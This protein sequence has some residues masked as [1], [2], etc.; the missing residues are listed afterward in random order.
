MLKSLSEKKSLNLFKEEFNE[1]PHGF[2]LK[3]QEVIQKKVYVV[4]HGEVKEEY[5]LF[6]DILFNS[7]AWE[8][9]GDTFTFLTSHINLM[10]S[11]MLK[12]NHSSTSNDKLGKKSILLNFITLLKDKN[13]RKSL[14]KPL[15]NYLNV[16]DKNELLN[17]AKKEKFEIR[18]FAISNDILSVY[19]L[20]PSNS[21]EEEV[22]NLISIFNQNKFNTSVGINLDNI[23]SLTESGK[24]LFMEK[25]MLEIDNEL[26]TKKVRATS[27][28]S[29]QPFSRVLAKIKDVLDDKTKSDLLRRIPQLTYYREISS[30]LSMKFGS[31]NFIGTPWDRLIEI[32]LLNKEI[33]SRLSDKEQHTYSKEDLKRIFKV[34]QTENAWNDVVLKDKDKFKHV[35]SHMGKNVVFA[36]MPL[37]YEA[38]INVF[39]EVLK[40]MDK[41]EIGRG[42]ENLLVVQKSFKGDSR[43]IDFI[44]D[45]F[46]SG[47]FLFINDIIS[48]NRFRD[49][50]DS[51]ENKLDYRN[52]KN[53][54]D[55][56]KN[57]FL[58]MSQMFEKVSSAGL[59][60]GKFLDLCD[61]DEINL[62][63]EMFLEN[64]SSSLN[65]KVEDF[66]ELF[67]RADVEQI[68][69]HDVNDTINHPNLII[70]FNKIKI[71]KT[72]SSSENNDSYPISSSQFKI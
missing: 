14:E 58:D 60:M 69:N 59:N 9:L 3:V 26:L 64:T 7:V 28:Y 10:N 63:T 72:L 16:C 27:K 45:E 33:Y 25:F 22:N 2:S 21:E 34:F 65:I 57:D 36:F 62:M 29:V 48:T 23:K 54:F 31:K 5:P 66:Y 46:N 67:K 12:A 39:E 37:Y 70:A 13:I 53:S 32:N 6:A 24:S 44:V 40:K 20:F 50:L 55:G 41:L 71:E 61:E 17:L 47:N 56:F 38:S 43:V 30:A 4:G 15:V 8:D 18:N 49:N 11:F 1:N 68:I 51:F 35:D 19:T 52:L 42:P